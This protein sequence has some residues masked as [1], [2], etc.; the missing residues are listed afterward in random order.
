MARVASVVSGPDAEERAI[1]AEIFRYEGA[2]EIRKVYRTSGP[3]EAYRACVEWALSY[4]EE[5]GIPASLAGA[6]AN[7]IFK[8]LKR[9]R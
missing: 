3:I 4:C 7:V 8:E 9:L 2:E 6:Y 5:S 1:L